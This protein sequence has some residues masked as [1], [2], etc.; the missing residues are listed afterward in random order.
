MRI[1]AQGRKMAV[2]QRT[3]HQVVNNPDQV[4]VDVVKMTE[5]MLRNRSTEVLLGERHS[6][7][8]PCPIPWEAPSDNR[9]PQPQ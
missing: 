1:S 7:R 3:T 5:I 4:E 6:S 8:F 2:R 9:D